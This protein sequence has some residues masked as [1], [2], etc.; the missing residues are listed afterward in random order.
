MKRRSWVWRLL[1]G[2]P[3][4]LLGMMVVALLLREALFSGPVVPPAALP[5]GKIVDM[6]AH[7][8][9]Y[10]NGG[11]G[12]YVSPA[13]RAN[14]RFDQ[15][16]SGFGVTRKEVEAHGDQVVVDKIAARLQ[17][18]SSVDAAVLLALDGV[19]DAKGELD[20]PR[21]EVYIPN[22]YVA[23]QVQ[24]YPKLFYFGASINP[25]RKDALQRLETAKRQGAV[26]VKWIPNIQQ[27][28]PADPQL[29][30]FYLKMRE[31]HLPLLSHTGQEQAFSNANDAF[32]DPRRLALPLS[33]GVTV[34][35]GHVATTG[36]SAGED[37]YQR[38]LPMFAQYPTLYA[39]ISSLTQINKLG[40]MG[41]ALQEP[42]LKGRLLYGSDFPMSNMIL[43][44]AWYFPLNL[45]KDDMHRINSIPN[46][47]DRDVALKQALG[48]PPD[49][50]A[51]S[52]Q[53]LGLPD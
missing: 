6:H 18:S 41:K 13:L 53:V 48:V 37:N 12:C 52:A 39:D 9:G 24:R 36:M 23:A 27:I 25:Y 8:A 2:V 7:I 32:G 20:L 49:V 16:L 29:T 22:A 51:R 10:G 17:A 42:R 1:L 14:F 35:A 33:L 4:L 31:L 38:I 40:F 47:W 46:H 5:T 44:S 50:F 15:Y 21:T 26:L 19:V 30:P 28:D 11:S 43:S 3:V 34:I 45:S